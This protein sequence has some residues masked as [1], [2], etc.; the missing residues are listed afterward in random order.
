MET[1]KVTVELP[2]DMVTDFM[3]L[4]SNLK[5][6]SAKAKTMAKA[7]DLEDKDNTTEEESASQPTGN[8]DSIVSQPKS[9]ITGKPSSIEEVRRYVVE[10]D[11]NVNVDKFYRYY[12]DRNWKDGKGED[13]Q[14]WKAIVEGWSKREWK[15]SKQ[16]TQLRKMNNQVTR[17]EP[18]KETKSDMQRM[19]ERYER[20][21]SYF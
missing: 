14:D 10:N 3:D 18:E 4:I 7:V 17:H 1:I 9:D 2:A 5:A 11:L 12:S 21:G 8:E 20:T 19:I 13:I 15:T 6:Y 16:A